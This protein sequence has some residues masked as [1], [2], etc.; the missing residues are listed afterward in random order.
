MEQIPFHALEWR[1]YLGLSIE[2]AAERAEVTVAHL[3]AVES[4]EHHFDEHDLVAF[5]NAY[6]IHPIWLFLYDPSDPDDLI[7]IEE[8]LKEEDGD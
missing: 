8:M 6:N 1:E 7:E 2:E 4:R 3:T 5:A